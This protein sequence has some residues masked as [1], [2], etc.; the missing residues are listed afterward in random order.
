MFSSLTEKLQN[1]FAGLS[2]KKTLTEENISDAVRQ[3][4]LALLEAD[5]NYTVVADFVKRVKEKSLGGAALK[6]VDPGQQFIKLV[7]DELVALMGSEEE[8][9]DLNGKLSV[10]ML[11]GLQGSGKTTTCA[12]LA[13]HI[14]RAHAQKKVLMAA[15]DLQRPAAVEQLKKLGAEHGIAVFA[16]P[17]ETDPV[18]VALQAKEEAQRQGYDVVL[19]DTA[20]RLHIDDDLMEQLRA[21]KRV[22]EPREVLFVANAATGQDAVTTASQF[23]QK[24]GITGSILTMLDS[25]ARAGAA[26]SIREVTK[27]PLK[28]EGVGEKI[29]DLQPF[30][31]QSMADRILGMGDIVNLV[32]KAHDAFDEAE[33]ADLEKK[34]RKAAFTYEDYLRQMKMI[35]RMGSFKSIMKMLP[36]M[37]TLGD[38]EVPEQE[39]NQMEAV[40]LSMTPEERQEK[41]ELEHSRRKRVA[42]GSGVPIDQVNRMVKGF[43][44][45]KQ[46][47]KGMPDMKGGAKKLGL[48]EDL[49]SK[50]EGKLWR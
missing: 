5:V 23:D 36:G 2:R 44:K 15:C 50:F 47:F 27:K 3:V 28:F 45:L 40:I 16:P 21:L 12:K 25:N 6:S 38:L 22:L 30:H 48:S 24:V 37:G 11:C 18:S 49:M 32:R 33:T 41:V 26:I 35:R 13:A 31:P 42:R 34:L 19:I 43:K 29:G 14:R 1:L 9:L 8:P 4:R 7:H 10:V 20:G 46:L 17:G 39:L